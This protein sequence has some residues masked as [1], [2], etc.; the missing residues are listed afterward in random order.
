MSIVLELTALDDADADVESQAGPDVI[1]YVDTEPHDGAVGFTTHLH[2]D[3]PEIPVDTEDLETDPDR[4]HAVMPR[5]V[6]RVC[7]SDPLRAPAWLTLV[8]TDLGDDESMIVEM[9]T[10][11]WLDEEY[12]LGAREAMRVIIL[13]SERHGE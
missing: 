5:Y 4:P 2:P 8:M 13:A 11:A 3:M 7:P 12:A 9:D 1:A 10:P 6:L